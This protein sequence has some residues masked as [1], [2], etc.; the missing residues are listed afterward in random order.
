MESLPLFRAIGHYSLSRSVAAVQP[1]VS[2]Q[3]GDVCG[4]AAGTSDAV[5]W[6]FTPTNPRKTL[7]SPPTTSK[8]PSGTKKTQVF[9][10]KKQNYIDI[11]TSSVNLHFMFKNDGAK[12]MTSLDPRGSL[13][14]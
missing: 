5:S 9:S 13:P 1:V 14:P 3:N 8:P 2:D 6:D 11:H 12:S 4:C 10:I 7:H